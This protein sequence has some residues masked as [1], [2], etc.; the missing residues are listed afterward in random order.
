MHSRSLI[1]TVIGEYRVVDYIG[2]GGMGEVYR[3]VHSRLG[4]V[5]AVKVLP[6]ESC[7]NKALQRF[8]NEATIQSSL[9]HPN[10][11][12]LYDF[13]EVGGRPC[14]L[15][16]YVDGQTLSERIASGGGLPVWEAAAILRAVALAVGYLHDLGVTHRDLKADNVKISS[17][18][19]VKLLDFGIAKSAF[20][21]HLTATDSVVGTMNYLSPEQIAEGRADARSD[22]WALGALFYE[23][24]TG[25]M[26]FAA[27]TIGGLCEAIRRGDYEPLSRLAPAVPA[28]VE[29]IVS[30][31]LRKRPADRFQ[32]TAD[33]VDALDAWQQPPADE[34]AAGSKVSRRWLKPLGITLGAAGVLAIAIFF[35]TGSDMPDVPETAPP[36]VVSASP[37]PTDSKEV[38]IEVRAVEGEAAV[39]RDGVYQGQTPR[40]ITAHSGEQFQLTLRQNG[41]EDKTQSVTVGDHSPQIYPIWMDR[42]R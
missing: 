18:G 23:M 7:D 35:F 28:A 17:A 36:T 31:C 2:A 3:A 41:Y 6:P 22:I 12:A 25:K 24:L 16:E 19:Q 33:L 4:R 30:R 14:L 37:K 9:Q 29:K 34:A 11:V 5:A 26:P 21:P 38:V 15:M 40:P 1:N 32:S 10:I 8:L 20:S 27:P 42:R 13:V 39:F